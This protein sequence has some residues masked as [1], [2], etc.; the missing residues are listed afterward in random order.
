MSKWD[1]GSAASAAAA[2]AAALKEKLASSGKLASGA[3]PPPQIVSPPGVAAPAL[4]AEI[5]INDNPNRGILTR[6]QK[7]EELS[8]TYGVTVTT[9]GRYFSPAEKASRGT[10]VEKPLHLFIEAKDQSSLDRVKSAINEILNATP[11][12]YGSYGRPFEKRAVSTRVWIDIYLP[13]GSDFDLRTKITGPNNAYLNHIAQETGCKV[14]LKGKGSGTVDPSSGEESHERMNIS[15]ENMDRAGLAAAKDLCENLVKTAREDYK[16]YMDQ[17]KQMPPP[18]QY[19]GYGYGGPPSG[20]YGYSPY[21][22]YGGYGYPPSGYPPQGYGG[23]Q[24]PAQG[25]AYGPPAAQQSQWATQP[26]AQQAPLGG[27]PATSAT[28]APQGSYGPSA[29]AV[30]PSSAPPAAP[31]N[32]PPSG[33][34]P[35]ATGPPPAQSGVPELPP[36]AKRKFSEKT[37]EPEAPAPA[38]DSSS[39]AKK[40]KLQPLVNYADDD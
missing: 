11:Q 1:A 35:P 13:A 23:Y 2:A 30:P 16:V 12:S 36:P 27:P 4:E 40:Q 24:Q 18:Q 10:T 37:Y 7:Q 38:Q 17:R 21:G 19:G 22:G 8:A 28:P 31:D 34:L 15:L 20:P 26:Y 29:M 9:R 3:P 6:G 32:A 14:V 5:E 25:Y 33:P 39:P